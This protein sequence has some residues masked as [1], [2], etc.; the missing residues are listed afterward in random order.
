MSL[1]ELPDGCFIA[2]G[3]LGSGYPILLLPGALAT[4]RSLAPLAA[5]LHG[6]RVLTMDYRS[7]GD[8]PRSAG[9]HTVSQFAQDVHHFLQVHAPV[10]AVIVGWSMGAL[11]AWELL[12]Q[13]PDDH[14][15]RGLVSL[16]Q[17]PSDLRQADW[18][19]GALDIDSMM[20]LA[21]GIQQDP[22]ATYAEVFDEPW[23]REDALRIDPTV[24]SFVV[25]DQ[26]LR[27]YR[28]VVATCGVPTL[29]VAGRDD[30]FLTPGQLEWMVA[31]GP[32]L[33]VSEV[34]GDHY[35]AVRRPGQVATAV[36]NFVRTLPQIRE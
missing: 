7:H 13:H 12:R 27:D 28:A 16:G 17:S 23:Q 33:T 4:K 26:T 32:E 21:R 10:D 8:S 30:Q 11:V 25:V 15:L 22:V 36:L 1:H 35:A 9:G 3:E 18:P 19:D 2:Y 29:T 20:E 31:N 24:A 6:L 5:E 34:E 14:G